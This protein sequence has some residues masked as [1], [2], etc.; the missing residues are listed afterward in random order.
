MADDIP[1]SGSFG[2]FTPSGVAARLWTSVIV[3]VLLGVIWTAGVL[4]PPVVARSTAE[5]DRQHRFACSAATWR[6]GQ[7]AGGGRSAQALHN[8]RP[9][10][11]RWPT[12]RTA[13]STQVPRGGPPR[14]RLRRPGGRTRRY[15]PQQQRGTATYLERDAHLVVVPRRR[16]DGRP[17]RCRRGPG[18]RRATVGACR[19]LA[20]PGTVGS[21]Q[22]ARAVAI[23]LDPIP[24]RRPAISPAGGLPAR[25]AAGLPRP[26]SPVVSERSPAAARPPWSWC[27]AGSVMLVLLLLTDVLLV[28]Y[29]AML[30]RSQRLW[31]AQRRGRRCYYVPTM[32][33]LGPAA[34]PLRRAGRRRCIASRR[35]RARRP[36]LVVLH[37]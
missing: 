16:R 32:T 33:L 9:T 29:V 4:V 19:P 2:T 18:L 36:Q 25:P 21:A 1:P 8:G 10:T 26:P 20:V 17:R 22:V 37:G 7:G 23:A 30:I 28:G 34:A 3:L 15:G 35:C 5:R 6:L 24:V 12:G 14:V 31:V 11:G 13:R 27:P